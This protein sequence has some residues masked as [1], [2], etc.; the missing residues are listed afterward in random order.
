MLHL[1]DEP[2]GAVIDAH[3]TA[4][5]LLIA[6]QVQGAA[7]S[8]ANFRLSRAHVSG[9]PRSAAQFHGRSILA[10]VAHARRS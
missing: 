5:A 3:D 2:R 8:M 1:R 6:E 4:L 10:T 7:T 9:K